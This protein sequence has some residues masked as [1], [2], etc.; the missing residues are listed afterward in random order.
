MF[1]ISSAFPTGTNL[2]PAVFVAS[3][4][5]SASPVS[6]TDVCPEEVFP[7]E[8]TKSF[9]PEDVEPPDEPPDELPDEPLELDVPEEEEV[10][11]D[12]VTLPLEE[13]E[14]D[15]PL[16]ELE[17]PPEVLQFG[18]VKLLPQF[19]PL[20][21]ITEEPDEGTKGPWLTGG[22]LP[23]QVPKTTQGSRFGVVLPLEEVLPPLI[24][25]QGVAIP[26]PQ[27]PHFAG[28]F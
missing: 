8:G 16:E 17:L 20:L 28:Q 21:D 3:V 11:E 5:S 6:G 9:P 15:V 2:H 19:E 24:S 12:D 26:F 14:V 23:L 25:S 4:T 7:E 18:P 27:Y 10:P 22:L 1:I 13:L